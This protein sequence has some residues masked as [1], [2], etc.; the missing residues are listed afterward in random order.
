MKKIGRILTSVVRDAHPESKWPPQF[1]VRLFFGV[2]LRRGTRKSNG[3]SNVFPS[4]GEV[5]LLDGLRIAPLNSP[6]LEPLHHSLE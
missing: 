4:L 6:L 2:P 5:L 3:L 1:E